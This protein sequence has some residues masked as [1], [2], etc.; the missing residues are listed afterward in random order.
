MVFAGDVVMYAREKYVIELE[1]EQWRDALEKRGMKVSRAKTEYMILNGTSLGSVK[2]QSDQLP[3]LTELKYLRST[4]QSDVDM[5]AEINRRT[6]CGWNDWRT[7]SDVL[8]DKRVPSHDKEKINKMI[9]QP[10]M[11][12]GMETVPMT[13]SKVKTLE[14]TEMK[15]CRWACAPLTDHVRNDDTRDK[16]KVENT[17][18]RYR[19]A[20][21]RWFGHVKRRDGWTVSTGTWEPSERNG[22]R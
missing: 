17:T 4:L 9:V 13:S 16:L 2:M 8:C 10:G 7:M 15:M 12:Y 19:K 21:L 11:L 3:Q 6:Q 20:R 14:V 1:L 22:N 5:N 18:E